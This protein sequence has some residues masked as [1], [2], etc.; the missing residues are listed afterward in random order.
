MS[1]SAH[2][3]RSADT[4]ADTAARCPPRLHI[5]SISLR[6]LPATP[7]SCAP[8]KILRPPETPLRTPNSRS[9]RHHIPPI[10]SF[11]IRLPRISRLRSYFYIRSSRIHGSVRHAHSAATPRPRRISAQISTLILS[12]IFPK[13]VRPKTQNL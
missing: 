8:R 11:H 5:P 3:V 13:K 2:C 4:A 10:S 9:P 7:V 6:P 12:A 1:G